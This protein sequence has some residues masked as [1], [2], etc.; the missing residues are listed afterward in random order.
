M[1]LGIFQG[2]TVGGLLM[3]VA[4]CF[5]IGGSSDNP[6][7]QVFISKDKLLSARQELILADEYLVVRVV[8]ATTYNKAS[9][10]CHQ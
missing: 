3:A 4:R 2:G 7:N 1:L 9:G 6:H 8:T 10:N 5:I